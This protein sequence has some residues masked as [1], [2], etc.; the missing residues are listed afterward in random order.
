MFDELTPESIEIARALKARVD[1]RADETQSS[2]R[3][4]VE[5]AL[6][7]YFAHLDR[8]TEVRSTAYHEAGHVVVA[9]VK[10]LKLRKR[11]LRIDQEGS[12]I[13]YYESKQKDGS[14]DI[15][16]DPSRVASIVAAYAGHHAQAR[17][18]PGCGTASACCDTEQAHDLENEMFSEPRVQCEKDAEYKKQSKELVNQRWKAIEA[19]AE[20][21]LAKPLTPQVGCERRWSHQCQEKVITGEEIISLLARHGVSATL[22]D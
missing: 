18:Y 19:L 13:A 3:E 2:I 20:A 7:G 5:L 22:V 1:Q 6:N 10:G 11:G 4:V 21:L 8:E 16:E 15:G 12:G 17:F 9:A 14:S